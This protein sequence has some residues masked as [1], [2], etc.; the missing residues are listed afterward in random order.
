MMPTARNSSKVRLVRSRKVIDLIIQSR[1][2]RSQ[3]L[4][5]YV[6]KPRRASFWTMPRTLRL[7]KA[8]RFAMK[9]WAGG[10]GETVRCRFSSRA[11]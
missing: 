9:S 10:L 8:S 1:R 6:S 5:V 3:S 2:T 7:R 11:A 4:M